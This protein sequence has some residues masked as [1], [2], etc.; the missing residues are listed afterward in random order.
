MRVFNLP[1]EDLKASLHTTSTGLSSGEAQRRLKEFGDNK[2]EEAKKKSLYLRFLQGFTHF[3]AVILWLGAGLAFFAEWK[4]PGGGMNLLG[5]AIIG[6]IVVNGIFSFWQEFKAEEAIE[7]LKKLMPCSVK[8]FRDGVLTEL[9]T[10][11]LVP[12][13]L[14]S[15]EEGDYVPADCRL[16]EA[17]GVRV[18]NSTLTGESMPQGRSAEE[19]SRDDVLAC[20]NVLLAGTT[21]SAGHGKA[22]VFH[23]GMHT[24]FGKIARLTQAEPEQLSPLQL[25]IVRL[26]RVIAAI[27]FSIGFILFIIGRCIGIDFWTNVVFALGVIVALVPEGLLPEVTLALATCSQRMARRNALVRHL[28]SVETLGCADV[29]CTDK[30][31]TLTENRMTV[32]E[33]YMCGE[34]FDTDRMKDL[35]QNYRPILADLCSI[36]LN[37]ENT[38]QAHS[39]GHTA[40]LGDPM[41][42]ALVN[43]ANSLQ[44]DTPSLDRIFEI[45]FDTERKRLTTVHKSTAQERVL[46]CKGAL[47]QVL[48]LCKAVAT[49]TQDRPL[50]PETRAEILTAEQNMTRSGLRVLAFGRR[51]IDDDESEYNEQG[52]TLIAL[53]ALQDPYR[54]EVPEAIERCKS[55][56]IRVIMITGDHPN[57]AES[58]AAQIGLVSSRLPAMT[59]VGQKLRKMNDTQLQ[60]MLA[61][62]EVIFARTEADQKMR[63]VKVLRNMGHIVAVTGDGVNDAPALK[64]A[65]VGIAMGRTGTDVARES[66]DLILTDDNFASIVN[67]IEEGRAV[68]ANIKKFLTYVLSSNV[69][70]LVPCLAFVLFK[71][72]CPLTVIQILSVDLGTDLIPALALGT[73]QPDAAVMERPPRSKKEGLFDLGLMC[74]AYLYLGL[75]VSFASMSGYFFMLNRAGWHP[76]QILALNDPNYMAAT[77]ACLMG[78]MAMQIVNSSMCRSDRKSVFTLG[79]FSNKMLNIGVIVQILMMGTIAYTPVGHIIFRTEAL[80]MSYWTFVAPMMAAFLLIEETRKWILRRHKTIIRWNDRAS[81]TS[82]QHSG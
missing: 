68:F 8:V 23:T 32:V 28:S 37:C 16:I 62:N 63:I 39:N 77:T 70:E 79:I 18:N 19:C 75:L 54:M 11:S 6:V 12:G 38:I 69:A 74:K 20:K 3:F 43:F 56:G 48:P 34:L 80:P 71:L 58:I 35:G 82:I 72:P 13:D 42:V 67:A 61:R 73:E 30:T 76:G 5:L 49:N 27:A 46:F 9:P 44:A 81:N 15:L 41:E 4:E 33:T 45:P 29:I 31:G 26:S 7:S 1:V 60:L 52:M 25:E 50:E 64:A 55:A 10:A 40:L 66:A 24:E 36:A 21:L 51:R 57:T 17:F 59:I 22:L 2:I 14:I 65:N 47:E 53:V 78:I